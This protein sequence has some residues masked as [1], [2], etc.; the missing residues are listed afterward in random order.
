MVVEGSTARAI[1]HRSSVLVAA[2][3]LVSCS[4]GE[5]EIVGGSG[6]A[7]GIIASQ[8]G[9]G[10][11]G[12][13]GDSGVGG[14]GNG[15]AADSGGSSGS[16]GIS[17][18]PPVPIEIVT[19]L[20]G[21]KD[22]FVPLADGDPVPVIMGPQGGYHIWTSVRI[23]DPTLKVVAVSL[24]SRFE[25]TGALVGQPS[26]EAAVFEDAGDGWWVNVG[27]R[28][29]IDS[30]APVKGKRVTLR[31]EFAAKDGRYGSDQRTIVP[32]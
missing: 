19:E 32:Q 15:G 27:M 23:H 14:G 1:L 24:T 29:F 7:R 11:G 10:Q 6:G 9:G 12:T 5:T 18:A 21:G 31:V 22:G 30:P 25:D 4:G 26:K 17:G 2:A 28:S 3:L 16:A 20:G 13:A 8:A